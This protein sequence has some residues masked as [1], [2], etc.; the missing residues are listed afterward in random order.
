MNWVVARQGLPCYSTVA[1]LGFKRRAISWVQHGS[2]TTFETGLRLLCKNMKYCKIP[3]PFPTVIAFHRVKK[4]PL[5]IGI[6]DRI[7]INSQSC[8]SHTFCKLNVWLTSVSFINLHRQHVMS[9]IQ[10]WCER[11]SKSHVA[12]EISGRGRRR[13]GD[14]KGNQGVGDFRFINILQISSIYYYYFCYHLFSILFLPTTFTHTHTHDP[15]P[16]PTTH[17]PRHLATLPLRRHSTRKVFL[18]EF[19]SYKKWK[20]SRKLEWNSFV[21]LSMK[22]TV[23]SQQNNSGSGKTERDVRWSWMCFLSELLCRLYSN[24]P[25]YS[26]FNKF[27]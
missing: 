13:S 18:K 21:C 8:W 1:R 22:K 25:F 12:K 16:L 15:R 27:I 10:W 20:T 2:S 9:F 3:L 19:F 24:R 14:E 17:D 6:V 5:I 4:S 7:K 11:G 23:E 26:S